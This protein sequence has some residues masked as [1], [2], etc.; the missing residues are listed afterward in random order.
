[1]LALVLLGIPDTCGFLLDDEC[2]RGGA[3]KRRPLRA[4]LG[5]G[6]GGGGGMDDLSSF[7]LTDLDK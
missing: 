7:L 3:D 5:G 1:M 6:G 4:T 2:G